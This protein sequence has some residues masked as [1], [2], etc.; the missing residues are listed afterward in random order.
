MKSKTVFFLGRLLIA[1]LVSSVTS[2]A[3]LPQD[4]INAPIPAIADISQIEN[5]LAQVN[6]S[7]APAWWQVFSD[8]Q[9]NRLVELGLAQSPTMV[10][11][12]ERVAMAQ[13]LLDGSRS[14]L[15]PQVGLVGQAN[16]QQ[17]S[18]NY[19][20]MPN[21]MNRQTNYGYVAGTFSWSLDVWGKQATLLAASQTRLSGALIERS[22]HQQQLTIAIVSAYVEY[23]NAILQRNLMQN[24]MGIQ[25]Q[26]VEIHRI[27]QKAGL[28]D[29]LPMESAEIEVNK[30]AAQV[31]MAQAVVQMYAGQLAIL[32]GNGPSW[33]VQ[34]TPPNIQFNAQAFLVHQQIPSD[35]IA[36]RADLQILLKQVQAGNLEASAA[37][38]DYLPSFDLQSNLGFQSF[39]LDRLISGASQFFTLGPVLNLPIFNGGKIAANIAVKQASHQEAIARYHETL[40]QALKES[41]DGITK[42]KAATQQLLLVG[43]ATAKTEQLFQQAAYRKKEGLLSNEQLLQNQ[44]R[45]ITQ[46]QQYEQTKLN[47]LGAYIFLMNA[48]G[49]GFQ[50]ASH[51][52]TN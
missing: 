30:V 40:L 19:I 45:V 10:M 33:S 13:A 1:W 32:T 17:L 36:R 28:E 37:K 4:R 18:E 41:A 2:C 27:R 9:L 47:A 31:A 44:L 23:D 26:L 6:Q 34:L 16:R 52:P 12:F 39:G 35:L 21:V 42:V 51:L 22:L 49:G 24:L 25:N 29:N 38:L 50:S 11:A 8:P 20:F 43:K 15:S 7:I 5:N 14:I 46:Q 48:L 3:I